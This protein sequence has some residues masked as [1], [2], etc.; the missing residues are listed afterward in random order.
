MPSA[1]LFVAVP[2]FASVTGMFGSEAALAKA[3]VPRLR[4][5]KE[6]SRLSA[7]R[8]ILARVPSD[9]AVADLRAPVAVGNNPATFGDPLSDSLVLTTS[10]LTL[11]SVFCSS[12]VEAAILPVSADIAEFATFVIPLRSEAA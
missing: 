1:A 10:S 9:R 7:V 3:V 12:F 4:A 11:A 6:G 8:S 2:K 5:S